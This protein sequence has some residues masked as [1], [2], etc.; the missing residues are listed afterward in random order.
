VDHR[1]QRPFVGERTEPFFT[2]LRRCRPSNTTASVGIS[3]LV[4]SVHDRNPAMRGRILATPDHASE[5]GAALRIAAGWFEEEF[6]GSGDRFLEAAERV[7]QLADATESIRTTW[8]GSPATTTA[9]W[10]ARPRR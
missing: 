3:A 2:V 5:G 1:W 7:S 6:A 9:A 8:T 4:T 10:R